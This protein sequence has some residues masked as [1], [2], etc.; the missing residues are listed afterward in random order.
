[1]VPAAGPKYTSLIYG[2][3]PMAVFL[4]FALDDVEVEGLELAG[5][6]AWRAIA[7]D[8]AIDAADGGDLCAGAREEQF[9]ADE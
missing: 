5:D 9:V 3:T 4:D 8:P 2:R 1:M 7:Q 6:G